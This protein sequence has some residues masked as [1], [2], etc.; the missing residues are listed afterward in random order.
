VSA[1]LDGSGDIDT[2]A[3]RGLSTEERR[4]LDELR[5]CHRVS[6]MTVEIVKRA[7]ALLRPA[8]RAPTVSYAFIA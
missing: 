6:E 3:R 1:E 2:G 7:S 4:E 8:E 5:R